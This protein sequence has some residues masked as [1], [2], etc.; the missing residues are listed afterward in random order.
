MVTGQ[1][2]WRILQRCLFLKHRADEYGVKVC[3]EFWQRDIKRQLVLSG[4]VNVCGSSNG[5]IF[6]EELERYDTTQN[7]EEQ[8]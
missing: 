1:G 5:L 7:D 8:C 6:D 3:E 4:P 2:I